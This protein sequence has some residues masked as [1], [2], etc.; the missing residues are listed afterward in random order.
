MEEVCMSEK[1]KKEPKLW[2]IF[3]IR[4]LGLDL[5]EIIKSWTGMEDFKSLLD[6]KQIEQV[7][8]RLEEQRKKFL[9]MQEEL[10]K[11]YGDTIRVDYDIHIGG[12]LGGKEGLR[13]GGGEF[14]S[15]MDELAKE[16]AEWRSRLRPTGRKIPYTVK[17]GVREP[18]VEF[19]EGKEHLEVIVELPGIEEKDLNLVIDEE[20]IAI[21]AET[22]ERKY[23]TE[24]KLPTKVFSEPVERTYTNGILRIKLKKK[25]E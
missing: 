24:Q 17:E 13:I 14:F 23:H 2:D 18:L 6:S 21:S 5:G 22:S 25:A 16:R 3:N 10:R 4:I 19:I 7:K 11:K 12:L 20:K 8:E 9:E 1:E 15:R